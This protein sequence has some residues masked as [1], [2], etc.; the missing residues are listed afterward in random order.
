MKTLEERREKNIPKRKIICK[1]VYHLFISRYKR[2]VNKVRKEYL[3]TTCMQ[4]VVRW[5]LFCDANSHTRSLNW[6]QSHVVVHLPKRL[7]EDWKACKGLEIKVVWLRL[8]NINLGMVEN[9]FLP[10][11]M[12][13]WN[14]S[15]WNLFRERVN[16]VT[17]HCLNKNIDRL[18]A[19]SCSG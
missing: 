16:I 6:I 11:S 17:K 14:L 2:T 13:L 10:L 8:N 7:L 15:T 5:K 19:P 18:F 1:N 12:T 4:I 9:N 3:R